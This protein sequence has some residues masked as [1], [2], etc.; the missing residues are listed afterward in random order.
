MREDPTMSDSRLGA[1]RRRTDHAQRLPRLAAR[2]GRAQGR[3]AQRRRRDACDAALRAQRA[4]D[5]PAPR[6][7]PSA[8]GS[9]SGSRAR[10]STSTSSPAAATTTRSS[11]R[12]TRPSSRCSRTTEPR[13][14]GRAPWSPR[15]RRWTRPPRS[16]TRRVRRGHRCAGCI[17]HMIEE[18][19][20]HN[21]HLDMMREA[22]DGRPATEP[23]RGSGRA[24]VRRGG[25]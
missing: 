12:P 25:A 21:G 2:G 19:A 15:S 10:T 9:R 5:H 7:G 20:R 23:P 11:W 8:C 3:R 14:S 22:I 4:R 13:P 17:L 18:T 1:R 24:S 16:S 6:R